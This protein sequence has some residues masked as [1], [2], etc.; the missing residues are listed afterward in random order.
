MLNKL[1]PLVVLTCLPT[2]PSS[3]V[4]AHEKSVVDAH[5]HDLAPA[6]QRT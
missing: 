6:A 5:T 1:F 4:L 3:L 2:E